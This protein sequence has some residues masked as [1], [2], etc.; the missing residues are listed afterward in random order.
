[1]VCQEVQIYYWDARDGPN[2]NGWWFGASVGG[3]MVWSFAPG[4][5]ATP[6]RTGTGGCG[7]WELVD[8]VEDFI[9][10]S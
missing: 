5:S 8:D 1:M 3:D 6:P 9:Q 7:W 10:N 4:D 2:M